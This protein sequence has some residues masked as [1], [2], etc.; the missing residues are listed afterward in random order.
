MPFFHAKSLPLCVL[1]VV[2]GS[3]PMESRCFFLFFLAGNGFG[4]PNARLAPI[5]RPMGASKDQRKFD[6][7]IGSCYGERALNSGPA[8]HVHTLCPASTCKY[9][10]TVGNALSPH[11]TACLALHGP[12][13]TAYVASPPHSANA[14]T[15]R[16]GTVARTHIDA[17][18]L[19]FS[20]PK[21]GP[22]KRRS[23]M[24]SV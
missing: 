2:V 21:A 7:Y 11:P 13:P 23:E 1:V 19:H 14:Q 3:Q 18:R 20:L 17:R 12:H 16:C 9:F 10:L 4:R 8:G 6:T 15:L 5:P 22:R 24:C